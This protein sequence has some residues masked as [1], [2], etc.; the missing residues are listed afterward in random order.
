MRFSQKFPL[1][2]EHFPN[3]AAIWNKQVD[4]LLHNANLFC[5]GA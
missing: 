3:L 1:K 4:T 2:K 5:L